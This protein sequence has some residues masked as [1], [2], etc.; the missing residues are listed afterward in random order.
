MKLMESYICV[1]LNVFIILNVSTIH[2][3]CV[4]PLTTL[5]PNT[6]NTPPQ[7]LLP[8]TW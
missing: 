6:P 2:A 5:Y 8:Q 4:A 1:L 7:L 3:L